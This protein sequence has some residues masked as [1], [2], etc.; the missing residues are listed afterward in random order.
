M[1]KTLIALAA[2]AATGAFAQSSVTL[3]GRLDAGYVNAVTNET[4]GATTN[5]A[6]TIGGNG[7]G[8][9]TSYWGLKGSEDLGGGLKAN[10]NLEQDV[11][12]ASGAV[13]AGFNRISTIGLAG[14]FGT[15]DIGRYYTPYFLNHK[16][17]DVNDAS[18]FL[19]TSSLTAYNIVGGTAPTAG[20][21]PILAR[22]SGTD[23]TVNNTT[24]GGD[25]RGNG[26]HYV[27]PG[28]LG[29]FALRLMYAPS[30][31]N[32][33]V[34][35]VGTATTSK[36]SNNGVSASYANGPL[37]VGFAWGEQTSKVSG[38]ATEGKGTGQGL[39]AS[40]D[41]GVAKL[42]ANYG[43]VKLQANTTVDT[44]VEKTETNIG[45][46]APFGAVTVLAAYGRNTVT[47]TNVGAESGNLS[48]NDWTLGATY[49]LSKRTTA[50]VKTGV[51]NKFE[52]TIQN[53]SVDT[54]TTATMVGLRH[55][56]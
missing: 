31:S 5:T 29:G 8:L 43:K 13:G 37:Y 9:S 15:L 1:K 26:L 10:F 56:F 50:Y 20:V 3:Y 17:G 34:A 21:S 51:T 53:V 46:S 22:M 24:L 42:F 40:Y 18:S 19:T 49:A 12:V 55:V 54:K 2:L 38:A 23:L 4:N 30:D 35:G 45:V 48:G 33:D 27:T 44:Y 41:F 14:G 11:A 39:A 16:T 25:V 36:V 7:N 28:T 52:G 32:A 47:G 6:N